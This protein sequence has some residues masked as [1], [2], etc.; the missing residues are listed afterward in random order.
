MLSPKQIEVSP[1]TVTAGF[2]PVETTTCMLS[3]F[4]QPSRLEISKKTVFI[5][6]VLN[7]A[8]GLLIESLS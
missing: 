7:V 6:D 5:P 8:M 1:V 4:T 2:I 3:F